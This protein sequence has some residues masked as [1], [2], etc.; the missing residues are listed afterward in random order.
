MGE[1]K[2]SE[3]NGA[4]GESGREAQLDKEL[5]DRLIEELGLDSQTTMTTFELVALKI[6][7]EEIDRFKLGQDATAEDVARARDE[8]DKKMAELEAKQERA[9]E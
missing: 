2:R 4:T 3:F 8:Y 7:R 9:P 6:H 1:S 5:H